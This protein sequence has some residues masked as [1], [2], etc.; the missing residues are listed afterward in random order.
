MITY[1]KISFLLY[2]LISIFFFCHTSYNNYLYLVLIHDLSSLCCN[3]TIRS[4][5]L[6]SPSRKYVL[7]SFNIL[8]RV[9]RAKLTRKA[10]LASMSW[11]PIKPFRG[12]FGL[13][14]PK[15][16][17][18]VSLRPLQTLNW[19]KQ[20][21]LWNFFLN[22]AL[23]RVKKDLPIWPQHDAVLELTDYLPKIVKDRWKFHHDLS[24]TRTLGFGS[25]KKY[26]S[27]TRS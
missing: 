19:P 10:K 22:L 3:F 18:Q 24:D 9:K 25:V 27:K 4:W 11:R 15:R 5:S 16:V 7:I 2:N 13:F 20:I 12:R 1:L 17:G 26:T 23:P 21:L 6:N 14:K 8:C